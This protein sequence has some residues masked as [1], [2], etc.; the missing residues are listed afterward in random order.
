MAEKRE[1]KIDEQLSQLS[2]SIQETTLTRLEGQLKDFKSKVDQIPSPTPPPDTT[3][4]IQGEAGIEGAWQNYLGYF[5]DPSAN[6]GLG[7]D[8]LDQFLEG[9]SK[10]ADGVLPDRVPNHVSGKIKV[11]TERRSDTGNQPD[12]IIRAPGRFF[13][14]CEMK[15]YSSEKEKQTRSYV[16]D[17]Q[18]GQKSKEE[19]PVGGHH[20]VYIKRRGAKDATAGRFVNVTWGQVREWLTPLLVNSRGGY[21]SRTTAQLSDFLDTIHQDMTDDLHLETERD[22]MDLYF[23]HLDAIEEARDGLKTVYEHAKENW[24]RR[25]LDQHLPDTWTEDWHCNPD[26]NGQ[27]YHSEWRQGDGLK[28]PD[29]MVRMHFVH[30]IRNLESFEEG[31]LTVELRWSGNQNEYK[32]RFKKLFT[33]DRLDSLLDPALGEYNVDRAPNTSRNIPRFTR[34]VYDVSRPDLPESYF[35]TLST[36][37]KEHQQLAP[38][39]NKVLE[40]AIQEV[41]EEIQD[42]SFNR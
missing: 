36:A 34:K 10:H 14:C 3:L 1:T 2:S 24:K 23:E 16:K 37:V 17:D 21:P 32:D 12:L 11:L 7:T 18:V 4:Q 42:S 19:F 15:L 25:F 41:D 20:Y 27:F 8:A 30:L 31:E 40:T 6:H 9:F 5:L 33:S 38:A 39:I 26:R 35:E 28:L 29:G 13:V 22:K